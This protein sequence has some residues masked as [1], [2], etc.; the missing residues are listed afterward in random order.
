MSD[1]GE[2]TKEQKGFDLRQF[3]LQSSIVEA[4]AE[5]DCNGKPYDLLYIISIFVV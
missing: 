4:Y 5:H 2:K 1:D 3:R